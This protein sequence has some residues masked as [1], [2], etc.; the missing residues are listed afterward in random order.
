LLTLSTFYEWRAAQL[1]SRSRANAPVFTVLQDRDFR[2][3][4]YLGGLHEISRRMELLVLSWLIL[5]TTNSPFQL[6]LILVFNNLPRPLF[7][8]FAGFVADRFSRQRILFAAQ[9]LNTLVAAGILLLI[10]YQ[11]VASWHVFLA[12]FMQGLTKSLEDPSRRTAILDIVGEGRLVNALSLD[13][14]SNTVGK[15]AGP[16]LGGVLVDASGFSGAYAFVLVAHFM[17]LVQLTRVRI[18]LYQGA[19]SVGPIWRS[20][21]TGL[22]FAWHNPML[23]GM[24]YVTII[25]NALAFPVQQFI[26]AIGRDN[27]GVGASLVGLLAAAEG[28]GQLMGAGLMASTRNFQYHGRVFIIGSVIVLVAA[29]LFVWSPWYALAFGFLTVGGMGQAGFGTMQSS[30]T[31]LSSP[32]EMRGRMMGLMSFCI[33]LG[34]PLGTL[35]IG[36]VAAAFSTQWAISVNAFAGLLLLVPAVVLTPLVWRPSTPPAPATVPE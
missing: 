34:T 21:S 31:M 11:Q 33:G 30:I 32:R 23:L 26:P 28:L 18:P 14:I 12:V 22:K 17:T 4:W 6:G 2:A 9:T 7:S 27:L 29:I 36:A 15:M 10:T 20:L 35:E 5:E 13:Q 24:L 8:L 16:I 3:I 25:M 19:S 1:P